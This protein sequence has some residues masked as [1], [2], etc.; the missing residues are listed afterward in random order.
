M[1]K[2]QVSLDMHHAV[3]NIFQWSRC[4]NIACEQ[5]SSQHL[6]IIRSETGKKGKVVLPRIVKYSFLHCSSLSLVE[7]GTEAIVGE[8]CVQGHDVSTCHLTAELSGAPAS[9]RVWA[10]YLSRVRSSDLLGGAIEG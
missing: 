4:P 1:K 5:S 7:I 8:E 2:K 9:V 6:P 3:P 10:L